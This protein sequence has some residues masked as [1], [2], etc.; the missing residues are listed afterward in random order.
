MNNNF[1]QIYDI[2]KNSNK[3]L[4]SL[5]S[6][7]D[8]DSFG[9][10]LAMKYF[11]KRDFKKEVKLV[12]FDYLGSEFM[13]M[14]YS[15]EVKFG[16]D[17]GSLEEFDLIICLD[18][19]S[20]SRI[21]KMKKGFEIPKSINSINI[22]HHSSNAYFA[23]YNF[24][25]KDAPSTCSIL[26]DMF[27]ELEIDID[28]ELAKRLLIGIV[29]DTEFFKSIHNPIRAL[30]EVLFLESKGAEYKEMALKKLEFNKSLNKKKYEGLVLSNI[31]LY[32][33]LKLAISYIE[34]EDMNR[35]NLNISDS[36]AGIACMIGIKNADVYV[37]LTKTQNGIKGSI[38]STSNLDVSKIAQ[39]LGG[40]GHNQRAGFFVEDTLKNTKN[41]IIKLVKKITSS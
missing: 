26:L 21:G 5:H 1:K 10:C 9:S 15:K 31:E 16:E 23:D 12:S 17:I 2:I 4:M 20:P 36:K 29:T 38:R 13:E 24:V 18:S 35:L 40:G 30:K 25:D 14:P 27:K 34:L 28:S 3:I 22:D 41:K 6:K 37:L 8:G 32:K 39:K 11:I 7:P 33:D 19:A